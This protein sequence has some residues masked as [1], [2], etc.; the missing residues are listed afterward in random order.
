MRAKRF[1]I[2]DKN[3]E[4][5]TRVDGFKSLTKARE[6]A[7][8][9]VKSPRYNL[10]ICSSGGERGGAIGTEGYV[11]LLKDYKTYYFE[12]ELGYKFFLKKDGTLGKALN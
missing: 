12:N 8:Y 3:G 9:F 11:G 5:V 7:R 4:A 10:R 6:I 1:Y 2:E